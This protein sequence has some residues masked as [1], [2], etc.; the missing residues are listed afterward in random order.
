M[1]LSD[2]VLTRPATRCF[3]IPHFGAYLALIG[4]LANALAI[5]IMPQ[6]P[7]KLRPLIRLLPRCSPPHN[8]ANMPIVLL[9][10]I[11]R[12]LLLYQDRVFEDRPT[13]AGVSDL[14]GQMIVRIY[15]TMCTNPQ[16]VSM[17]SAVGA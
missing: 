11:Y 7:V 3:Q 12:I 15:V 13:T 9:I 10:P 2:A 16:F 17:R 1:C 6:V 4:A 8:H 5:Y 14:R